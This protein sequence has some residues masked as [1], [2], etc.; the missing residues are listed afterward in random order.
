MKKLEDILPMGAIEHSARLFRIFPSTDS[1]W[2]SFIEPG[3]SIV[4]AADSP[5]DWDK[6]FNIGYRYSGDKWP[7]FE[8]YRVGAGDR[9]KVLWV[10]AEPSPYQQSARVIKRFI[11]QFGDAVVLVG[12]QMTTWLRPHAG[13]SWW[14]QFEGLGRGRGPHRYGG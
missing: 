11:V 10:E 6:K 13:H 8:G 5:L 14:K 7:Y 1:D 12:G 9:G 3:A 4:V 2:H